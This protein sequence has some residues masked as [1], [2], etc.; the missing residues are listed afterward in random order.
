MN[1]EVLI[2]SLRNRNEELCSLAANELEKMDMKYRELGRSYDAMS[3]DLMKLID[4]NK[5]LRDELRGHKNDL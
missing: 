2:Q 1:L 5:K 3:S 4:E